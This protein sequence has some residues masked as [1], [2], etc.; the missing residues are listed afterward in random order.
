VND[1]NTPDLTLWLG[2]K[3]Q[4]DPVAAAAREVEDRRDR[5]ERRR[6]LYVALTRAEDWLILCGANARTRVSDSWYEMLAN[7]MD[8]CADTV[9]LPSPT[10]EGQMLRYQ[11]GAGPEGV[12]PAEVRERPG[13]TALPLWLDDAPAE[14]REERR[15]P[16]ELAP[17]SALMGDDGSDNEG[18]GGTGLG[19]DLAKRRGVAVHLLLEHIS[20]D[21][22]TLDPGLAERLLETALPDEVS[23]FRDGVLEEVSRVLSMG[24]AAEIFGPDAIAEMSVSIDKPATSDP[25]PKKRMI[26]RI[27]RLVVKDGVV[28]IIDL[29]SDSEPPGFAERVSQKYLSQLGAYQTAVQR[30]WPDHRVEL[31]IL[32]TRTATL[33]PVNATDAAHAFEATNWNTR[34]Q[35]GT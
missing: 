20:P 6:L 21:T 25:P 27:D 32:W 22:V 11:T 4:D 12:S 10:G 9:E 35:D 3:D 2:P 29:K 18:Q 15:R 5:D 31:A 14:V 23:D 34:A 19:R 26:G 30:I 7:G 13:E 1:G 8:A 24:E 33:M 17:A 28:K 16:S